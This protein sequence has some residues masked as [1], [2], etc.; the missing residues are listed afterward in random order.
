[1]RTAARGFKQSMEFL[2]EAWIR[3]IKRARIEA[4]QEFFEEYVI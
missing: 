2:K 4:V 1:M 3:L